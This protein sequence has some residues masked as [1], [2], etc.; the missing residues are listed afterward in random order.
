VRGT[1]LSGDARTYDRSM[2]RLLV[3][4]PLVAVAA[5]CGGGAKGPETT[6]AATQAPAAKPKLRVVITAESHHPK[7]GHPWTYQVRVTDGA[8][9]KPVAC[10]IHLQFFFAGSPVGEVGT[11][12]VADGFWKETIPAKGKDAFPP[13]ALGF[14]VVLR[15]T[16]TA[17]GYRAAKSGWN[18]SVVK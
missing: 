10:R 16:V 6:T 1:V 11:H 17:P 4:L 9:G 3:L 5:A 7:L 18:V 13:A 15:A 14:S 8:T 2:R 12:R